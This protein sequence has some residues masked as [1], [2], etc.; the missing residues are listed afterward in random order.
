[1]SR[2]TAVSCLLPPPAGGSLKETPGKVGHLNLAVLDRLRA[3]PFLGTWR[4]L[5]CDEVMRVGAAG[6][7]LQRFLE[8]R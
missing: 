4:T 8:V 3:C 1:M 2:T 5:L 7:D 6:D